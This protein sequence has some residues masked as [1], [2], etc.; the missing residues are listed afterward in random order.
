MDNKL[1][2]YFGNW[3]TLGT[4]NTL[5][6]PE[7][8]RNLKELLDYL[9]SKDWSLIKE[10]YT[11]DE[12]V[13]RY[14]NGLIYLE[15]IDPSCIEVISDGNPD[16]EIVLEEDNGILSL[17][18]PVI[19][20]TISSWLTKLDNDYWDFKDQSGK[21]RKEFF[22]L[23]KSNFNDK[24]DYLLSNFTVDYNEESGT[25]LYFF[26]LNLMYNKVVKPDSLF[27]KDGSLNSF[28]SIFPV[29]LGTNYIPNM[30][31]FCVKLS[32]F[33]SNEITDGNETIKYLIN[34]LKEIN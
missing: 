16:N 5:V 26:K 4:E 1:K 17:S 25:L 23:I 21:L 20:E 32:L 22:K 28:N 10:V 11:K 33:L 30:D 2:I 8:K 29:I 27:S 9:D 13:I 12:D 19:D 14:I 31:E 3:R 6:Y 15:K 24:V 18:L 7:E 34:K